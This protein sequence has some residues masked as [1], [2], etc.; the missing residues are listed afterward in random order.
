MKLIY[1]CFLPFLCLI[2]LEGVDTIK[3][4]E[5]F[6]VGIRQSLLISDIYGGM[7]KASIFGF[8]LTTVGSYQGYFTDGG[9]KGVVIATT[10]A[11]V[12]SSILIIIT[13]YFL[14]EILFGP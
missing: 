9:A 5:V 13:N 8:I 14:A 12:L 2:S 11:V 3:N 4:S 1:K 7:F 10:Q 6:K